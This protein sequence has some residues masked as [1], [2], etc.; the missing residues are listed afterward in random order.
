MSNGQLQD[1]L[2]SI[3]GKVP[4]KAQG[5]TKS[6][7]PVSASA[8]KGDGVDHINVWEDGV[9]DMGRMLSHR[10]E[11]SFNHSHFGR[12]KTV[13]GFDNYIQSVE[14][15]DR[16]RYMSGPPLSH[17]AKQLTHVPIL[18]FRAILV[19]TYY[20]RIK[21][22]KKLSDLFINSTLPFDLY[23]IVKRTGVKV[24]PARA[25]WFAE[26]LEEIRRAM[27]EGGEPDLGFLV[28]PG[29]NIYEQFEVKPEVKAE[30]K[31]ASKK[32]KPAKKK[33]VPTVNGVPLEGLGEN[34]S[35]NSDDHAALAAT[36]R[37]HSAD[38][39]VKEL[40]QEGAVTQ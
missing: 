39:A 34:K 24:R 1:K 37:E 2:S 14:K 18:Y 21:Q 38:V 12:F 8:W 35:E 32:N 29:I 17:L 30:E 15:D 4:V 5:T 22:D 16:L 23:Y 3:R 31:N 25:L 9:T 28:K 40:L 6:I 36:A 27:Q 19:D 33:P 10:H 7:R 13:E 20:Q 11:A 26:G